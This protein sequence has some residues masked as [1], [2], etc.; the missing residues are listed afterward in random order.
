MNDLSF[1]KGKI[2]CIEG[3]IGVGKTSL[4]NELQAKLEKAGI[5]TKFY[6][7]PFNQMMLEQFLA[8]PK[9]YAY[10]FQLYMLTRRQVIFVQ[11]QY[12][13]KNGTC[14]L[15]DRSLIGD[16]VFATLQ[17]M[18][19]NI[20]D[21]DFEIYKSV[22]E[23]FSEFKPHVVVYLDSTITTQI[24]RINKRNRNGEDAYKMSYLIKLNEAYKDILSKSFRDA[25]YVDWNCNLS[26]SSITNILE[27][28][29]GTD[30]KFYDTRG[31]A[32]HPS[33]DTQAKV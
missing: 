30:N 27:K 3:P 5:K 26:D 14:C 28:I 32:P 11:A 19:E 25:I 8:N 18:E 12:E 20:T 16:Y 23:Q 13:A 17:K 33:S 1:F 4:C 21:H 15:I 29:M 6:T 31:S 22:Y 9:Q 2:C 7:E 10:A 24:T